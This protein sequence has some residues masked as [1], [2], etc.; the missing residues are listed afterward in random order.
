MDEEIAYI[1]AEELNPD[2]AYLAG[3][4]LRDLTAGDV[5][6]LPE[7]LRRSVAACHFY[8]AAG[9]NTPGPLSRGSLGGGL[10]PLVPGIGAGRLRTIRQALAAA[11]VDVAEDGE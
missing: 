10:A 8:E 6:A 9:R 4:P 11:E 1:Y 2:G 3:V 7:W 5:A